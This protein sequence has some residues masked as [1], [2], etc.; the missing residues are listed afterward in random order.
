MHLAKTYL[1]L[2]AKANQ[3]WTYENF[4]ITSHFWQK[5]F[6]FFM[7]VIIWFESFNSKT[8]MD[9][10]FSIHV[11]DI[12]PRLENGT[13]TPLR[14]IQ[15]LLPPRS[16]LVSPSD[17]VMITS[18]PIRDARNKE[19]ALEE[20]PCLKVSPLLHIYEHTMNMRKWTR[21]Y[22]SQALARAEMTISMK[23]NPAV[24]QND[25]EWSEVG[26]RTLPC[27]AALL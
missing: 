27:P 15:V 5:P 22:V 9:S 21:C 18:S 10:P 20:P 19:I 17:N 12:L 16:P 25:F 7:T 26:H 23:R 1:P 2:F 3:F 8:M 13:C 11:D 24:L 6:L 14:K 4:I